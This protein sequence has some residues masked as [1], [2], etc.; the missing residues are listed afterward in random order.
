MK[1]PFLLLLLAIT[2]LTGYS[3]DVSL[4]I[5][6]YLEGPFFS[7]QM[8]TALNTGGNV[9]LNQPYNIAPWNYPGT[10]SV[11]AMPSS[12][13]D[14]VLI[15]LLRDAND[16]TI[17]PFEV[18]GR[19]AALLKYNGKITDLNGYSPVSISAGGN[20]T[21]YVKVSHRNHLPVISAYPLTE[22]NGLY[23]YN[24]TTSYTQAY[25]GIATLKQLTGGKWGMYAADGDA[26]F[27]IDNQD[28]NGVW[29]PEYN[30]TGYLSG[31]YDMDG[32]VDMDDLNGKWAINAGQG[33]GGKL[34]ILSVCASNPRY[35]CNADKAVYLVG[36]HTWDNLQD[37]GIT[38]NYTDYVDWL[39][40]M[41]HNFMRMWAWENWY[42]TDWANSPEHSISPLPFL[43]VGNKYDLT[44]LN[45]DYFD[46]LRNRIQMADDRGIYVSIMLFEGFSAEH[47][48]YAWNYN[49]FKSNKN[50][51][52]IAASQNNV[53][54][55]AIPAVLEAQKLYVREIIDM[56]NYYHLDNVLYEI[57][58]EIPY[59]VNSD[60]W[61]NNM[62]NYIHDYEL[63][64]YG[65]NRPVG[66]TDQYNTG[67]NSLLFN[68]PADWISPGKDSG[69]FDCRDGHAPISNGDKVI[70]SDT[71]HYYY[72]WYSNSGNP[73]D[74]V[75]KSF[76]GG[77]N[78]IH[79]DNWGGGSNIPGYLLG[80]SNASLFSL[81]RN[82]MGYA[83]LLS[84]RID[85]ISTTPQ[86]SLSSSG[87]CLASDH[88]F[89]VYLPQFTNSVQLDLS[90]HSG[91]FEVEWINTDD[92]T[93]NSGGQIN[94]GNPSNFSSP[95]G[96]YSVLYLKKIQ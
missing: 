48:P 20:S 77:I 71:D 11:S 76:T 92:G 43:K 40:S 83:K 56:V 68:S 47:T 37:M 57:G 10:E 38:F 66:K 78:A 70:I 88:E 42:G 16:T 25:G 69:E 24:F 9:P 22:S 59:S 72:V 58:N 32:H 14:W 1:N 50:I 90:G 26:N 64:T 75:W 5:R 61:Q 7:N 15:E 95:F 46:R 81:V 33:S 41:N 21:F 49:P 94:G 52:G 44:Q 3:Q 80:Q 93:I 60:L 29:L 27:Q 84:D 45:P 67:S 17:Q 54:T 35:F 82:N 2:C 65:I 18:I 4:N 74:Y 53:H 23:S 79:M 28:K 36:S 73:V 31:D 8:N 13:V 96:D 34:G 51:N 55:E 6:I 39:Q 91:T 30:S 89:V 63:Q 12:S 19:K 87:F 62:I 85:L 86:P